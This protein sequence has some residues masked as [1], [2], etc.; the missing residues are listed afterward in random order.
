MVNFRTE[1]PFCVLSHTSLTTFCN[2]YFVPLNS[3]WV[4]CHQDMYVT[5]CVMP[6]TN[7]LPNQPIMRK[8]KETSQ[9]ACAY[10]PKPAD[11]AAAAQ[12]RLPACIPTL[13]NP[14]RS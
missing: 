11:K 2:A 14:H 1:H 7:Q 8:P 10:L 12:S 13:V 4:S 6:L 5:S 9:L 3:A